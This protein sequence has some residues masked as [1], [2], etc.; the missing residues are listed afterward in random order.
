MVFQKP[1]RKSENL[2]KISKK[3][4]ATLCK[5]SDWQLTTMDM[6][7]S[8]YGSDTINKKKNIFEKFLWKFWVYIADKP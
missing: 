4:L 5:S 1:G 3:P 7:S 8:D 6:T 2:E